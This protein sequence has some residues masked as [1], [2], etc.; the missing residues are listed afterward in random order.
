M[1]TPEISVG[2]STA[3]SDPS[4][5]AVGQR[6]ESTVL[7][8]ALVGVALAL[9]ALKC[10][11]GNPIDDPDVW[12]HVRAGQWI[13]EHRALPTVDTFSSHGMGQPWAAYSWTAELAL[14]GLHQ[15][16]GLRGLLVYTAAISVAILLAFYHLVRRLEPAGSLDVIFT[17]TATLGLLPVLTPRPW[18]LSILCLI[19]E[20]DLLLTAGRSG[21]RRLLLWLVP[22]F[23]LWANTHIQFVLGLVVLGAAVAE[24]LLTKVLPARLVNDDSRRIPFAWMLFVFFLCVGATLVNPYHVHL[25]FVA[26]QL[27]DQIELWNLIQEVGAMSFRSP[28][29]WIVLAV[30]VAAAFSLGWRRRARLL[31]VLLFAMAVYLGF[32]SQ[33]DA[34]FP[35]VVGLSILAYSHPKRETSAPEPAKPVGWAMAGAVLTAVL[36][37]CL[38]MSEVRLRDKT[39]GKFPAGAVEFIADRGYPGPMFN[40]FGWGGYLMLHL[41]ERS[42]SIDGRTMVHG[43]DRVV[44]NCRTLYGNEQWQEDPELAEADLV[45]LPRDLPLSSLLRLDDRFQTVYEDSVAVVFSRNAVAGS[46]DPPQYAGTV[47]L[48]NTRDTLQDT[49]ER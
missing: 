4:K 8:A 43:T 16:L 25:Y 5:H 2:K 40:S 11:L 20:L 3:M 22:L 36:V 38:G 34:W 47:P 1:E 33:R 46:A 44:R 37:A 14:H 32:R 48:Q 39:A 18:L 7:A 27:L 49:Q 24:P 45:I 13:V 21:N 30:T 15:A 31:L 17:L 41:P 12:W 23:V 6:S 26:A 19:I 42:V 10:F 35:L 28:S 9:P 29:N